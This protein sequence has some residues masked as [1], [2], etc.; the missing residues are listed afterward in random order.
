MK[1]FV[2][3][4]LALAVATLVS[5]REGSRE[6][7]HHYTGVTV[8]PVYQDSISIRAITF[9]D[10][11]TLAFA[12]S[13]GQFGTVDLGSGQV[14]A[15]TLVR[16]S[17]VPE[18]RAVAHTQEDFFMLSAGSPALLYKTGDNGQ[19][20][21]VYSE[22]GPNV[23]YDAMAFWNNS[24]GLAIGDS[25]DG[26]LA[27]LIT[28]DGGRTWQKT[29]CKDLPP[30]VANEGAFAASNTN[31]AIQGNTA[32]VATTAGRVYVTNDKGLRW[33]VYQTPVVHREPTQG[34]YSLDFHNADLG[35][36]FGGDFTKP[37]ARTNNK[38]LT[39]DGGK[40]WE[41]LANGAAPGYKSCVRFV[42]GSGG[43]DLVAVGFTGIAYSG[44]QGQH[45]KHLSDEGFYTVR[46]LNDSTAYAAGKNRIA[47]L[48]FN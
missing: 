37:D 2:L 11:G 27:V 8:H 24:E 38:A 4:A 17:L 14:R 47:K 28:R 32:W 1:H 29:A 18:F 40:T 22:T 33:N 21:L 34:I 7:S 43:K 6:A 44:D 19:M 45:W 16:D 20:Q 12:G 23:F 46:F 10:Y 15:N 48:V 9:L 41:V 3:G 30:G 26:C 13:G 42:P 36:A 35:I 39:R 25:F 5:C 31:I